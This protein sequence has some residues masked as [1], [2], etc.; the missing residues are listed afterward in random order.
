MKV[1]ERIKVANQL[2]LKWEDFPGLAPYVI[3]K[4]LQGERERQKGHNQR[5]GSV[6]RLGPMSLALKMEEEDHEPRNVG[7]KIRGPNWKGQGID[8]PLEP[9]GCSL[10]VCHLH[11]AQWDPGHTSDPQK[12][13]FVLPHVQVICYSIHRKL[14]LY[15]GFYWG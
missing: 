12:H 1:S 5:N 15:Y 10:A 2:T 4:V 9:P 6:K 11:L 3:T 13:R 14:I 7:S 8:F